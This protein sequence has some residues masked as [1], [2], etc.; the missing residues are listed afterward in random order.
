[1]QLHAGQADRFERLV[2]SAPIRWGIAGSRLIQHYS[3]LQHIEINIELAQTVYAEKAIGR[4]ES[5]RLNDPDPPPRYRY[6]VDD[7]TSEFDFA[8]WRR[9]SDATHLP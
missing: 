3:A 5:V 9:I 8:S 1:M 2:R 6:V 4:Q 7:K